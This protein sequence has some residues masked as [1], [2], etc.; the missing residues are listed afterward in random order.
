MEFIS[1]FG[2]IFFAISAP[3]YSENYI[4]KENRLKTV[5]TIIEIIGDDED[6]NVLISYYA[7]NKGYVT[8][9]KSY[10]SS[11]YEG[12]EIIIYYD[13][14]NPMNIIDTESLIPVII[15]RCFGSVFILISMIILAF[16]FRR[17]R[18][19]Q[20]LKENGLILNAK[21]LYVKTNIVYNVNN[22]HP[23]NIYCESNQLFDGLTH[24][25]KSENI[26]NDPT[27]I[28]EDNNIKHFKV[29]VNPNNYKQYYMDISI[30]LEKGYK[31][32]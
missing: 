9:L 8:N 14:N 24:K 7:N 2:I 17:K 26:W 10:N 5:A 13:K 27:K 3:L 12:K 16:K 25:F 18:I 30:L 23:F 22:K 28:I 15:L 31:D 29:Y 19:M 11:Y 1:F 20:N 32:K 21:Y 6:H 4:S